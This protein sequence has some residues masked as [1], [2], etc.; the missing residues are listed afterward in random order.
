MNQHSR[1]LDEIV[2]SDISKLSII[3][4]KWIYI[5][6]IGDINKKCQ[7]NGELIV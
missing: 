3:Q 4:P 5:Q 1:V 7:T 6:I 2:A